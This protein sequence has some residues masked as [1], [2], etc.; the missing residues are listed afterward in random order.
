MVRVHLAVIAAFL[1]LPAA[2]R[3]DDKTIYKIGIPRSMFRD[4]PPALVAFAAQPFSDLVKDQTGLLAEVVQDP[5]AMSVAKA[6]D[7]GKLHLGVFQGHEFAWAQSKYPKLQTL[8]C[9][10]YRP[11]EF[12]GIILVRA[13]SKAKDLGD[14]K[15]SKLV[16]ASTLKDH[17]RLF[18]N[19]RRVDEMG[20]DK[21]GSTA[22]AATVH[23]G[24]HKV[25]D[26]EADVTVA[27]FADWSYFQKLYPGP[28]QN[29]KVL[30]KSEVFPPTVLV[31]NKGSL[32]EAI[33]KTIR[34]G[35]LNVHKSPK[36]ARMMGMIRIDR[37]D[38]IPADYDGL[39]KT[40]LKSYPRP[41]EEK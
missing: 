2:G 27:D 38:P 20:D 3:G 13:D 10:V 37:F 17:A 30:S 41:T 5:D 40:T 21:F 14:L 36:G 9:L 8:V 1:L 28:S 35:F 31:Y 19:K 22:E 26:K 29:L 24:I 16:L 39:L 18:L 12:Q 11:K 6:L 25:Q 23:E 32:D 34:D 15:G 7:E 4:L 33:L